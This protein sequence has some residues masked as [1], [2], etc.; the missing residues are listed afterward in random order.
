M[1]LEVFM[2]KTLVPLMVT[3]VV[4]NIRNVICFGCKHEFQRLKKIIF[5]IPNFILSA[6]PSPPQKLRSIYMQRIFVFLMVTKDYLSQII[7]NIR[8]VIYFGCKNEFQSKRKIFFKNL[9]SFSFL[10]ETQMVIFQAWFFIEE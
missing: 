4:P 10:Y 1:V 8:D 2:Q 7:F 5:L 6:P 9:G 3:K